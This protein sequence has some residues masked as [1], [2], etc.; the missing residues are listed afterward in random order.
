MFRCPFCVWRDLSEPAREAL[1]GLPSR[2]APP[3]R[4]ELLGEH[5]VEFHELKPDGTMWK[6]T[7]TGKAVARAGKVFIEQE[8]G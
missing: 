4:N 2:L 5:L 3:I 1:L 7:T 6:A 8:R